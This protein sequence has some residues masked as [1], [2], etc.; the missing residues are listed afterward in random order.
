MKPPHKMRTRLR[1]KAQRNMWEAVAGVML[2]GMIA[3]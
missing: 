1:I 2:I 3:K